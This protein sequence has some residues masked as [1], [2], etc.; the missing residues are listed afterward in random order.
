MPQPLPVSSDHCRASLTHSRLLAFFL[1]IFLLI[2]AGLVFASRTVAWD[3]TPSDE[4][5]R[6]YRQSWNPFS[7]GPILH[8]AVDL[9][10][11]GQYL[12]R[13]FIFSQ[14]GEHSFDNRFGSFFDRKSG[15]VHLYSVQEPSAE[16]AYGLSDHFQ[17]G[18]TTALQSFW[19]R[20]DG[21]GHRLR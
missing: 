15:P 3:W 7:H 17:L 20:E 12:L 9:Q 5:M 4:D 6:K 18:A 11:K 10:P 16:F 19:S 2:A 21:Y 14:I 8:T 1:G 13:P